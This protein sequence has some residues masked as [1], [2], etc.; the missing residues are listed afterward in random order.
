VNRAPPALASR[1][2]QPAATPVT[3]QLPAPD[4]I[5]A[6]RKRLAAQKRARRAEKLKKELTHG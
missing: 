3:R 1:F 2:G 5:Q 4:A 6:E